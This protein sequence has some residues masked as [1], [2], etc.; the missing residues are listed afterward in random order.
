MWDHGYN[1]VPIKGSLERD[2]SFAG[3]RLWDFTEEVTEILLGTGITPLDIDLLAPAPPT[4]NDASGAL[5]RRR[6]NQIWRRAWD[7]VRRVFGSQSS[8]LLI[9]SR[10]W[11]SSPPDF[12]ALRRL[13]EAGWPLNFPRRDLDPVMTGSPSVVLAGVMLQ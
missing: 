2:S 1:Q 7:G 5:G 10:K 11:T 12:R 6:L 4:T 13:R 3:A 8:T 9:K